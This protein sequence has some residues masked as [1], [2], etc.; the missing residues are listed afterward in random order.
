MP[1]MIIINLVKKFS[2]D[3]AIAIENATPYQK[4]EERVEERTQEL[5][6]AQETT[7]MLSVIG[8]E[9]ISTTDFD[10]IFVHCTK[11]LGS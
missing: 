6:S 7:R 10:S 9:I 8:K 1:L 11:K 4:L 3:C 2:R 5:I